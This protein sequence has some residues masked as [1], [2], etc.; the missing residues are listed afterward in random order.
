MSKPRYRWWG[1][2]AQVV[3][4]TTGK[5][6]GDIPG[7]EITARELERQREEDP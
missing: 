3:V 5:Q 4:L 7:L 6:Y 2:D 1:D